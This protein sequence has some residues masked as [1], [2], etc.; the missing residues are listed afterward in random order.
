MNKNNKKQSIGIVLLYTALFVLMCL[1]VFG[2]HWKKGLSFIFSTDGWNQHFRALQFYSDWLQQIVRGVIKDFH[3]SIPLW[4]DVMGYGADVIST[5]HYYVIGDPLCLLSVFIPDRFMVYFYDALIIFRFFLAGVSF[6]LFALYQ[7]ST[8]KRVS[9][10]GVYFV[11]EIN[12][13]I[14]PTEI[15][16]LLS[17]SFIYIFSG[18]T[19]VMGLHHP[20]FINPFIYFPL[21]L[22]GVEKIL[23]KDS[24]V[25][26]ILMVF[27]SAISNF[28]F[29]YMI[30]FN[31]IIY[32]CI[33]LFFIYG[34]KNMRKI[35]KNILEIGSYTIIGTLMSCFILVPVIRL[36]THTARASA[37]ADIGLLYENKF[38]KKLFYK[39]F[40]IPKGSAYHTYL[41]F[42]FVVLL[43][44][45]LLFLQ[46]KKNTQ[47]KVGLLLLTILL[48]LPIGGKILNGFSYPSNRWMFS[49]I[50][51][52]AYVVFLQW[53]RIFSCDWK[54]RGAVSCILLFTVV[55]LW[56]KKM[57]VRINVEALHCA[58]IF[59]FFGVLLFFIA[60]W[61][62]KNKKIEI[63]LSIC[64]MVLVLSSISMNAFYR[65]Q[66][67]AGNN[68]KEIEGEFTTV[69]KA[70]IEREAPV[71]KALKNLVKDDKEFYRY[72]AP[73][74]QIQR[75]STLQSGLFST[76]FFWS[77]A[78][79]ETKD[80]FQHLTVVNRQ[81]YN[82]KN[83]D[84][85]TKLNTLAGVKYFVKQKDQPTMIP[86]G[87][88]FKGETK[89]ETEN[90]LQEYQVYENP[91]ALPC[92]Y[93]YDQVVSKKEYD[94]LNELEREDVFM[95][96]AF[97]ESNTEGIKE[98]KPEHRVKKIP[99]SVISVSKGKWDGK[100]FVAKEKNAEM[101]LRLEE[102]CKNSETG[103]FFR[104]LDYTGKKD[105]VK[106]KLSSHAD[107]KILSKKKRSIVTKKHIRYMGMRDFYSNLGYS[108][109]SPKEIKIQFKNKGK[110]SFEALEIYVQSMK[111]YEKQVSHLK[112]D[113]LE[114]VKFS[115]NK[116]TG[117]LSLDKKKILC[118]PI[119]YSDG[120]SAKIDGKK[121][122]VLKVNHMFLGLAVEPGNHQIEF[123]YWTP[124][125]TMG[126]ILSSAGVILF[127][128]LLAIN[129]RKNSQNVL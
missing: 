85:R 36:F 99:W 32:V 26:F 22:I 69:K 116:I 42:S 73:S 30:G 126:I 106:I 84:E 86:Y 103:I 41:G 70:K 10:N 113:S 3:F 8:T 31:V 71:E 11:K 120:W 100:N 122:E 101:V 12:E 27:I 80:F 81:E 19:L 87:Y 123:N 108:S 37:K 96:A 2:I 52:I 49:L 93:T 13:K 76:H 45:L 115:N 82:Y 18:Y 6:L 35:I 72:T 79:K 57:K 47:I 5:L 33:R 64:L 55:L 127:F 50:M 17:A 109:E 107:G 62:K 98:I 4:S 110:Y 51:L 7:R 38:Y 66:R 21:I 104:G 124:G 95:E 59:L 91:L 129:K 111:G 60:G 9:E 78:E 24:P 39:L 97:L 83:L 16:G 63:T 61:C 54:T 67:E 28:Y 14:S 88:I 77:L 20:Y 34:I 46:H 89:A 65:F 121:A 90:G 118:L 29:F 102:T 117:N 25:L 112:E 56:N 43:A 74:D 119:A 128:V 94:Q 15:C 92:G 40:Y 125:L 75:N 114:A 53:K 23:K 58:A 48:C 1:L 44:L 68:K 105:E